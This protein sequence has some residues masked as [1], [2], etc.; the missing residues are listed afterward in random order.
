MITGD[1]D[2][3]DSIFASRLPPQLI[4]DG[5]S[6]GII[7]TEGPTLLQNDDIDDVQTTLLFSDTVG[8]KMYALGMPSDDDDDDSHDEEGEERP[9][10]LRIMKDRSG[11]API[12]EDNSWRA[13]PGSNGI[14]L[15]PKSTGS[16]GSEGR[17]KSSSQLLVCQH[18]A[19]RLAIMDFTTGLVQSLA[20]EYNGKPLNGPNDVCIHSEMGTH[21]AYFTDPV[22]AWL[23]KQRFE[24]LPYL[25]EKVA[26]QGP[27]HCGVYRVE[28]SDSTTLSPSLK[29]NNDNDDQT[30]DEG[31]NNKVELV[32]SSLKRPNGIGFYTNK[33]YNDEEEEEDLMVVS[34]CCQGNHLVGCVSGISRWAIFEK[35][36]EQ[37]QQGKATDAWVQT[38]TIQDIVSSK[39]ATGGCADGFAF[40]DIDGDDDSIKKKQYMLASCFGGLCIV[41]LDQQKVVSRMWT[42]KEEFGG[43]KLSNVAVG[44]K[45]VF[46]TGNCG[47]LRLS[48][49]PKLSKAQRATEGVHIEL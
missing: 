1:L 18:G 10:L 38:R 27:G 42:G 12:D 33:K 5:P 17:S 8:D 40:L 4:L 34:D 23:E 26:K 25:D 35:R 49:H 48:L 43:C 24:D 6:H 37:Q 20:S 22:Y 7:W 14:A 3:W 13:E 19:Q 9:P 47:I 16:N 32:T 31:H 39:E 41:D 30:Y 15:L 2:V 11:D 28:I 29:N 46:L 36:Q 21:Y 44:K 45:H